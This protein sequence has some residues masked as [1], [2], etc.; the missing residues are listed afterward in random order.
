MR[1]IRLFGW[2]LF[3]AVIVAFL[4]G[5]STLITETKETYDKVYKPTHLLPP[6]YVVSEKL[7]YTA[8][9]RVNKEKTLYDIDDRGDQYSFQAGLKA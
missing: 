4:T 5:C 9:I 7:P 8:D 6:N 3:T 2:M 1:K